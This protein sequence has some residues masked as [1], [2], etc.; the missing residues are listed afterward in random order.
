ME[1]TWFDR[2]TTKIGVLRRLKQLKPNGPAAR[3][4]GETLV[5]HSPHHDITAP[6]PPLAPNA[7]RG[8]RPRGQRGHK[9]RD[10]AMTSDHIKSTKPPAPANP[11]S[12]ATPANPCATPSSPT[13]GITRWSPPLSAA[14][15]GSAVATSALAPEASPL[16]DARLRVLP[17]GHPPPAGSLEGKMRRAPPAHFSC[18]KGGPFRAAV[19]GIHA[20]IGQSRREFSGKRR[21]YPERV[22]AYQGSISGGMPTSGPPTAKRLNMLSVSLAANSSGGINLPLFATD[23]PS[24]RFHIGCVLRPLIFECGETLEQSHFGV[25]STRFLNYHQEPK[26]SH[27]HVRR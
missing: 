23:H 26:K 1:S 12:S 5:R 17:L 15:F 24:K 13:A 19:M 21:L 27:Q 10:P 18:A 11:P 2:A 3:H 22:G 8:A 4:Q 6:T 14:C 20:G 16:Q 9:M 25:G 7:D